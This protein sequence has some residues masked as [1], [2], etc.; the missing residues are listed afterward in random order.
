MDETEKYGVDVPK[1]STVEAK[2]VTESF[3]EPLTKEEVLEIVQPF[4]RS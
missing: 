4:I 2:Q 3:D 1:V